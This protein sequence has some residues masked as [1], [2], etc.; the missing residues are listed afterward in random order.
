ML[1]GTTLFSRIWPVVSEKKIKTPSGC[2]P[3]Q[4]LHGMEIYEQLWTII[5]KLGDRSFSD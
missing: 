2:M 3:T 4:I 1:T 5:V